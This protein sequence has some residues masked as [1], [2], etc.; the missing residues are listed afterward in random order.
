[1]ITNK[2]DK[3]LNDLLDVILLKLYIHW[4]L[5]HVQLLGLEI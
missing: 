5:N 2:L 3:H 1:M 4:Y